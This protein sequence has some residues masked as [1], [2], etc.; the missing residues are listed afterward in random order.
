M[1]EIAWSNNVVHPSI[2]NKTNEQRKEVKQGCEEPK[3]FDICF[4]IT[5]GCYEQSL[6]ST[7]IGLDTRLSLHP[8]ARFS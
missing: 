7:L 8:V 2:S 5:F 4:S 3:N 6:N 1:H